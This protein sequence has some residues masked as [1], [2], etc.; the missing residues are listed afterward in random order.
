MTNASDLIRKAERSRA[1]KGVAVK[2]PPIP[3]E[4]PGP[5]RASA[6]REIILRHERAARSNIRGNAPS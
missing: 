5:V 6:L 1:P 4:Q 3:R 2:A